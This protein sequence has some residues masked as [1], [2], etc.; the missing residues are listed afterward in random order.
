MT[1]K[2]QVVFRFP[3]VELT[4]IIKV[5]DKIIIDLCARIDQ[6]KVYKSSCGEIFKLRKIRLG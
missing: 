3:V 5:F 1:Y 6:E 4:L 2:F